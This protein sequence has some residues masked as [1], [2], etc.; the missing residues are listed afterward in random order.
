MLRKFPTGHLLSLLFLLRGIAID[1]RATGFSQPLFILPI[2]E[3]SR[4]SL[5]ESCILKVVSSLC[6]HDIKTN[7]DRAVSRSLHQYAGKCCPPLSRIP[8]SLSH[9]MA[10]HMAS[11]HAF[12]K[13]ETFRQVTM[14]SEVSLLPLVNDLLKTMENNAHIQLFPLSPL[15]PA[16]DVPSLAPDSSSSSHN[17]SRSSVVCYVLRPLTASLKTIFDHVQLQPPQNHTQYY[18]YFCPLHTSLYHHLALEFFHNLVLS[19]FIYE[20]PSLGFIMLSEDLYSLECN[21]PLAVMN[22]SSSNNSTSPD[23]HAIIESIARSL[24]P[25]SASLTRVASIGEKA[26]T[27]RNAVLTHTFQPSSLSPLP[28][29]S[30]QIDGIDS[31]LTIERYHD[32][33][34]GA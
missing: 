11:S 18:L 29:P 7:E 9:F 16:E 25:L 24:A 10:T 31:L 3:T 17:S 20:L 30:T 28:H 14:I 2:Q 6:H 26:R 12:S 33:L 34:I 5:S 19:V 13:L 27:C 32:L 4:E 15:S 23:F 22:N 21:L 8:L 1:G